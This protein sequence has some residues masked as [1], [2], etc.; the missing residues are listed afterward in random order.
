M[1]KLATPQYARFQ[2]LSTRE[3]IRT[4]FS[5]CLS[6]SSMQ[7][8][9]TTEALLSKGLLVRPPYISVPQKVDF[10]KNKN[11]M[12]GSSLFSDKRT[13]NAIEIGHLYHNTETN[14]LGFMV[15]VGFGQTAGSQKIRDYM[16][17]GK[18]IAKKHIKVFADR[19]M[20]SDI[21]APMSWDES[22][23]DSTEAPFSDKLMMY[24]MSL[25]AASSIASYGLAAGE[26]LRGDL[27]LTFT[28]LAAEVAQYAKD[29][30]DIMI[31]NGWMEKPPQ[32][33]DRDQIIKQKTQA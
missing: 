3:D 2:A 28:R 6:S 15:C 11:Y 14:V 12:D 21:Q 22:A 10:I 29:G 30:T 9:Q 33:D 8:N 24:H 17:R 16:L 31:K 13:L 26:S 19:L 27:A 1:G 5:N 18:D 25:L 4:F 7:F 20:E 32:A 23:K